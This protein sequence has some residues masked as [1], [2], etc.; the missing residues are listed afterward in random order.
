MSLPILRLLHL[1]DSAFPIGATAHSFG[2]ETLTAQGVLTAPT[3]GGFLHDLLQE[4][5]RT[6]AIFNRLAY[7]CVAADATV[8]VAAWLQLNECVGALKPA[9]ESREASATL[10]RRFLQT[11]AHLAASPC[12][13]QALAAAHQSAVDIHYCTAFGLVGGALHLGEDETVL[14]YLQQS[15]M[16]LSSACLRLLPIGQSRATE[17]LWELKAPMVAVASASLKC[18]PSSVSVV[19]PA[20]MLD[21]LTLLTPMLDLASMGH[22]TLTTRLFIS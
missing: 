20:A 18:V 9:R 19:E 10:G 2:L 13:Q 4:T 21:H 8:A 17:I 3:L 7:R 22:P 15:M 16:G 14:A 6:E 1:A 11:V 5:G 12:L